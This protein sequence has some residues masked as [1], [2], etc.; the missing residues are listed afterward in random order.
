MLHTAAAGASIVVPVMTVPAVLTPCVL[1]PLMFTPAVAPPATAVAI[2]IDNRRFAAGHD[3]RG[4]SRD[5]HRW[6]R[7]VFD[8]D[9]CRRGVDRGRDDT[10]A[11][12]A[13]NDAPDKAAE[14]RVIGVI[15]VREG[16]DGGCREGSA[17]AEND[18]PPFHLVTSL[19][20][21]GASPCSCLCELLGV[22]LMGVR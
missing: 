21:S 11:D 14:R 9:G 3:D 17:S 6:R 13:A 8:H 2:V 22:K 19:R 5:Y 4:R 1:A 15:A 16:S 20:M 10:G 18:K 7:V 12:E